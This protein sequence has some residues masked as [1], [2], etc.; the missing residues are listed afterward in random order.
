LLLNNILNSVSYF[1]ENTNAFV[2]Q[3]QSFNG[4]SGNNRS[5]F[6]RKWKPSG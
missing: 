1:L 5:M 4:L 3:G 2:L 6:R